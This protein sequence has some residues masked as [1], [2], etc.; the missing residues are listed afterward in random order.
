MYK[1]FLLITFFFVYSL[2]FSQDKPIN[3]KALELF[4][5]AKTLELQDNYIVAI[6]KYNEVLK[7]EKAAGVYYT[8]SKLYYYVSQ[9]QK[10]L[11]NGLEAL[12]LAPDNADYLDNLADV[13]IML[14]D[15]PNALKYLL[16]VNE[17]KP[18][19]INILYN[20]GRIY[21]AEKQPSIA[22]KYYE[23]ITEDFQYDE[24]VLKRMI[25]IYEGYKDYANSAATQE[26]LLTL[27]P[28]DMYLKYTLAQT[29]LK[30]PDW[31]N[32]LRLYEDILTIDTKNRE[33]QTEVIKIYFR[34]NRIN[35]AFEKFGKL[36]EK[37]TVD[38]STKMGIALAFFD[39]ASTDS[40]AFQ[41]AV[42]ILETIKNSYPREWMPGYYLAVIEQRTSGFEAVEKKYRDILSQADTSVEAHVLI[43]FSFYEQRK[44][45]DALN[46]FKQGAEKFPDEF[47]L[48]Y[49]AGDCL[50]RMGKQ[51]DAL[52]YLEK[53]KQ[54]NPKDIST[55]STLGIIYDNLGMND[56]C[57]QLYKEA[58]GYYPD[59]I[60]LLNNYAYHLAEINKDLDAANKMS[61]YTIEKEP[62]NPS[63][64]DTY[65]WILYKQKDY[66]NAAKYIEK[67]IR[68]GS[69]AVLLEHLGDIYEAMGEIVKALKYWKQSLEENPDNSNLK[70]KI[71]KYS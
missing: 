6:E 30:I 20:I 40:S 25:E 17:K 7:I 3:D 42:S 48:S 61:K 68:L 66:K 51:K 46:I 13:Y 62:D 52:A 59:N 24:N 15:Y 71:E 11:E 54:I 21:E 14:N 45:T 23:K 53:A 60:L 18:G 58:L 9:Y 37:D 33:I 49:L 67:A 19:D 47:R 16:L 69:N 32:A 65:G 5:E 4:I 43:G 38:F 12:K 1:F 39:V 31:D 22:I 27:S 29:Y 63:Y 10:S 55:L 64:L 44:Y 35:A 50:Y 2:S 36:I 28:S 41:V 26:K 57:E 70:S 34:Q 56:A 8:L